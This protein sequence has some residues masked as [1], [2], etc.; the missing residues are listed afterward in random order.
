MTIQTGIISI[1]REQR[2]AIYKEEKKKERKSQGLFIARD[3]N[4][5]KK[6]EDFETKSL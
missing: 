5:K 4:Y 6:E 1:P 3:E 2:Q